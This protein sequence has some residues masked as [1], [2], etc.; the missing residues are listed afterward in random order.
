MSGGMG[1]ERDNINETLILNNDFLDL[2]VVMSLLCLNILSP[3]PTSF[4]PQHLG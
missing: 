2:F 3:A 4:S 1:D